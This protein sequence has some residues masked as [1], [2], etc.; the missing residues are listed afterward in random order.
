MRV[1]LFGQRD[2]AE[3]INGKMGR[4]AE[5]EWIGNRGWVFDAYLEKVNED[6]RLAGYLQY[7]KTLAKGELSSVKKAEEKFISTFDNNSKDAEN[8][9]RSF[10]F[11]LNLQREEI[12]SK[13]REKL[14]QNYGLYNTEL[15][16]ELKSS[17]LTVEY[18]EGDSNLIEYYDYYTRLLSKYSF[19]FKEYLL[20]LSK[21]GN[22]YACDGALLI[23]REEMRRRISLIEEFTKNHETIPDKRN[24]EEILKAYMNDYSNG[25]D[26]TPVCDFR[27]NTLLSEIRSSFKK[28]LKENKSSSYHPF[29]EK[30]YSMY[31]KNNFKCSQEIKNYSFTFFYPSDRK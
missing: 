28:F 24:V 6:D 7:L 13:L 25:S 9:F 21:V 31:E 30:L 29:M 5:V 16:N 1:K 3:V 15:I 4:W 22:P 18:C 26:N 27:N 20:L 11:F 17:G 19:E 8:A 12:N 2:K 23:S 10:T 14:R